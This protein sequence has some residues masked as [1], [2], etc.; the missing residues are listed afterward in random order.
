MTNMKQKGWP[1]SPLTNLRLNL[2][3]LKDYRNNT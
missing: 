2:T 3:K 1:T